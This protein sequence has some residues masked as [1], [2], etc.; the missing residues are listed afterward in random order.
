PLRLGRARDALRAAL[1][2]GTLDALVSDHNPVSADE[3]TLPFAEATP[4]A[5][6]LE[7]LLP[8]ALKWGEDSGAGL[9]RALATITSEPV[10]ALGASLGSLSAS[11]G[12][13]VEGGVADVCVFDLDERWQ[14]KPSALK[15][16]GKHTPFAPEHTGF[17]LPGRV[18]ATLVA[19]TVA[20]EDSTA[21]A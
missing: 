12:R 5:T 8:L 20:Y 15:S 10:R 7:L 1:A 14:A 19:G 9:L 3:K 21:V 16:Q 2:D 13:L 11:A 6:G 17:E 18:K 4:G